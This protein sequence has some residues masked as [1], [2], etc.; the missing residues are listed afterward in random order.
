MSDSAAKYK[1][2]YEELK[3]QIADGTLRVGEKMPSETRMMN[4]TGYSR[5]TV[6]K[7][8]D[9]LMADG[10]ISKVQGSGSYVHITP[11]AGHA[12]RRTVLFL[13]KILEH[14]SSTVYAKGLEEALAL[15]GYSL[16][17]RLTGDN[18]EK[19]RQQLL[20]AMRESFDGIVFMP[21]R[22]AALN[23]NLS[24]YRKLQRSGVPCI[25]LGTQLLA[26]DIPY[27]ATDDFMGGEV[28][29]RYL[30]KMGHTKVCCMMNKD[31][32]AGCMRYA[33]FT[34][35]FEDDAQNVCSAV[36][37]SYETL[38]QMFSEENQKTLVKQLCESTVVFCYNDDLAV[39]V[40]HLL[41]KNQLHVPQDI[42]IIGYDD[43]IGY[44]DSFRGLLTQI[45]L[46]TV[47]QNAYE[48]G[49]KAGENI[50]ELIRKPLFSA[51]YTFQPVLIERSTVRKL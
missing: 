15:Q 5:Q 22:S 26:T 30:M 20:T 19:E 13:T 1:N 49:Y 35:A 46:T 41:E 27:I 14:Y 2:L 4:Q 12:Q 8:L 50:V 38:D 3:N 18:L 36:W 17:I 6:R 11:K 23:D 40:Y 43:A 16:T 31:E 9:L 47:R 24:L 33:G 10:L 51:S 29:A 42:S 34:T 25:A 28:V 37:Y 44:G 32:V 45:P 21:A 7:A 39:S 48:I